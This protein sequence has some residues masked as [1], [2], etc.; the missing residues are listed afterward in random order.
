MSFGSSSAPRCAWSSI[1]ATFA[2][3]GERNGT[4]VSRTNSWNASLLPV[5]LSL[6]RP[7]VR[8]ASTAGTSVVFEIRA[9]GSTLLSATALNKLF[10][11]S[12]ASSR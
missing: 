9:S 6:R 11:G 1:S 12:A 7:Y 5:V 3:N 8:T 4:V 2:R 10:F